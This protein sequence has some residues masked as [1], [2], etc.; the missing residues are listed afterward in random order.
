ME[1]KSLQ[2]VINQLNLSAAAF[3]ELEESLKRFDIEYNEKI[4]KAKNRKLRKKLKILI[5]TV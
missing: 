5:D 4:K 2:P 3:R 1:L